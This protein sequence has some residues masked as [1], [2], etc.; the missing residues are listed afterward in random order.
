MGSV[1]VAQIVRVSNSN[2]KV[3]SSMPTLALYAV[4]SLGKTLYE[5]TSITGLST[6]QSWWPSPPKDA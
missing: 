3:A 2:R 1:V 6:N 4:V 5:I